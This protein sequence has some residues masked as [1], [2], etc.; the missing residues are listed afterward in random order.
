MELSPIEMEGIEKAALEDGVDPVVWARLMNYEPAVTTD[1]VARLVSLDL[2]L[3]PGGDGVYQL[4]NEGRD[5][6]RAR[7]VAYGDAVRRATPHW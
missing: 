1:A 6:Q 2:M 3:R 4:T 5:L 7:A